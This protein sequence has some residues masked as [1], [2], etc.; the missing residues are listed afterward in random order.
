M[1][2][3]PAHQCRACPAVERG[4]IAPPGWHWVGSVLLCGDCHAVYCDSLNQGPAPHPGHN[5]LG[6]IADA[7]RTGRWKPGD[8]GVV[9]SNIGTPGT[10]EIVSLDMDQRFA[11]ARPV[12]FAICHPTTYEPLQT[13]PVNLDYLERENPPHG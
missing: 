6:R 10:V 7:L 12:D 9:R 5:A 3:A 2:D 4:V 1:A 13:M 8:R 11:I